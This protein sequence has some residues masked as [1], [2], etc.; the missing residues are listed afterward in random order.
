MSALARK[1]E[2]DAAA[3]LRA[4]AHEL[5]P[6]LHPRG[7]IRW[8]VVAAHPDDET[9]G[10]TWVLSRSDSASVLHVTDG[11]PHDRALWSPDAPDTREAYA[12]L[13]A[14][15]MRAALGLA[16]VGPERIHRLG[17][18]DQ[19]ACAA[20]AELSLQVADVLAALR[21][22]IVLVH[23]YEGGHPDHDAA[24]FAVRAASGLL[25][26]NRI[27]GPRIAEMTSY[28]RFE[29]QLRT[30]VFL[31]GGGKAAER[32][33]GTEE[34]ALKTRMLRS[35]ASQSRVLV[36]FGVQAERFRAAPAY[37]F[38]RPPHEGPLHYETLGWPMTG[39]R[40]R[41]LAGTALRELGLG[42]SRWR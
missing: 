10:A 17:F 28:H 23:P 24:A 16:G 7:E 26:R 6:D 1:D 20:L 34:R 4:L 27:A 35:F 3:G 42:E 11:A 8:L 21:P 12:R 18:A 31:P 32:V 29:G 19:K 40:W 2:V 39:A 14:E 38:T 41:E 36:P 5:F 13:R 15:E 22:D 9:I 33:L 37:D 25:A 30:G